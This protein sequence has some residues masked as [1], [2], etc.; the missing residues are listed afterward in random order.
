[1]KQ[2]RQ[3][4]KKPFLY[5]LKETD[6]TYNPQKALFWGLVLPGGG[7]FFNKD[8]WKTP[9]AIGAVGTAIYF[10]IENRN[11]HLRYRDAYRLR[12]DGDATTLDEFADNPNATESALIEIR[13]RYHKW[14][15]QSIVACIAVY[16][17][18]AIE[19]FTSAHLK[20]FDISDDLS[21]RIHPNLQWQTFSSDNQ[22]V[23]LGIGV[24][25]FIKTP[26]SEV[27]LDFME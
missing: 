14:F 25:V 20:D 26:Q 13:D 15:E 23:N 12:V 4:D 11:N 10:T 16:G 24:K 21:M 2:D 19:A 3:K 18:T 8:Y 5:F 1:M 7:Q 27:T 22:G 6:P 9:L 17:L